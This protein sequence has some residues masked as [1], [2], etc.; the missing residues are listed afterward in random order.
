MIASASWRV[1]NCWA[2]SR[3]V[4][5]SHNAHRQI[6]NKEWYIPMRHCVHSQQVF[7]HSYD[8]R[9]MTQRCFHAMLSVEWQTFRSRALLLPGAKSPQTE[10]SF[11]WNIRSQGAAPWNF[12]TRGNFAYRKSSNKRRVSIKRRS[13]INAGGSKVRVPINAGSLI[14]AGL[15]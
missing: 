2:Y 14:D 3:E 6:G 10:R 1:A 7:V 4:G 9:L 12:R 8:Q 13:L 5:V 15:E 11:S